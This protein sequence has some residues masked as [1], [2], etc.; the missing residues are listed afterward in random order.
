[1]SDNCEGVKKKLI[2]TASDLGASGKEVELGDKKEPEKDL[3]EALLVLEK[4]Q[5][6][7]K[8]FFGRCE[9]DRIRTGH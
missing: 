1:M 3:T 7:E 8:N 6:M 9:R 4:I 5:I 2:E